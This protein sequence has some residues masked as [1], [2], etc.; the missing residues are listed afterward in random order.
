MTPVTL[1]AHDVRVSDRLGT[2]PLPPLPMARH[3]EQWVRAA[4]GSHSCQ[5]PGLAG[6]PLRSQGLLRNGPELML[7]QCEWRVDTLYM[8]RERQEKDARLSVSR[9]KM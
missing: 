9:Q 5:I 4:L 3:I 6:K 7:S 1:W 8:W 2:P